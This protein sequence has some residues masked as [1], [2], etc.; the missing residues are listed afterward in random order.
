MTKSDLRI[1]YREARKKLGFETRQLLSVKIS[2]NF[3]ATEWSKANK[4]FVFMGSEQFM[5]PDTWPIIK[6]LWTQNKEVCIPHL[7]GKSMEAANFTPS[8]ALTTDRYGLLS[9]KNP[10]PIDPTTLDVVLLPLL[11]SDKNGN[12]VGYGG[13]YYDRFLQPLPQSIFRIGLNFFSPID[14]IQD[15][16]FH[17][18]PIHA[19][20]SPDG[21]FV[22]NSNP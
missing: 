16:V 14:E 15:A 6:G 9:P 22:S 1:H 2:D 18:V 8:T 12:R 17:D 5:E 10:K 19:L 7:L 3:F 11:I 21:I 13:G 20:I 4:F